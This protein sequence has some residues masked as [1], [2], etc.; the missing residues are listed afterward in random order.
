MVT[1]DETS[2]RDAINAA[3]EAKRELLEQQRAAR[4]LLEPA[5]QCLL[6]SSDQVAMS[7]AISLRRIADRFEAC[8]NLGRMPD[9]TL[10]GEFRIDDCKG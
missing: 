4:L 10:Y 8:T 3:L 6:A 9:G 7:M 5:A 1:D 2:R